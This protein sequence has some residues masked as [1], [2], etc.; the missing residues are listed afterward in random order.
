MRAG[1]YA[2]VSTEEQDVDKQVDGL[3]DY[4]KR[5]Y[6]GNILREGFKSFT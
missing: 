4:C 2:R 5:K 1:I 3:V 6:L